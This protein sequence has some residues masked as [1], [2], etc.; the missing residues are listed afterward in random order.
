MEILDPKRII[1][2]LGKA[3]PQDLV[4]AVAQMVDELE[5]YGID[6]ISVGKVKY[7]SG[8][9]YQFRQ[10]YSSSLLL[11]AY[12]FVTGQRILVVVSAY[13][14]QQDPTKKRQQAEIRRAL[15]LKKTLANYVSKQ[16]KF[17]SE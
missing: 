9:M 16:I 12:F 11:R 14:K 4:V 8:G 3:P 17:D 1:R 15:K 5:R 10:R 13:N 6:L 7:I 2:Q